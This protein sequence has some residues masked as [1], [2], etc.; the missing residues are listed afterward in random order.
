MAIPRGVTV[1]TGGGYSGKSTLLDAIE[2]GIYNHIPGDGREYVISDE[3]ALKICAEDGRP[4]SNL[5]ISPFFR[6][7]PGQYIA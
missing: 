5:D 2:N 4:V 3:S 7:L 1:I 6:F